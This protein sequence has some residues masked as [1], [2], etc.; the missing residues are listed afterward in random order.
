[1]NQA[2]LAWLVLL[3]LLTPCFA[4]AQGEAWGD[5]KGRVVI[6]FK[7]PLVLPPIQAGRNR[8]I[9]D[10]SLLVGLDGGLANVVVYVRTPGVPVHSDLAK[11]LQ[12]N[13]AMTFKNSRSEPRIVP[14]WTQRQAVEFRNR[15]A[16]SYNLNAS[17]VADSPFNVL[18][19]AGDTLWYTPQLPQSIPVPVTCTIQPWLKAYVVPRDNPYVAVT[20]STGAFT[21]R[22]LPARSLEF[23]LWHERFGYLDTPTYAQ[24]RVVLKLKPGENDLGT[25]VVER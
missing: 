25:I 12:T 23:Q 16:F 1:M 9:P 5:L 20:R 21:I 22:K 8:Q 15:E 24:G 19:I 11:Q 3:T 2:P 14:V 17:P 13:V 4:Q 10:E 7:E 18:L 6:R